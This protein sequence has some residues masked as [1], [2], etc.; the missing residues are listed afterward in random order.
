M[1]I[2]SRYIYGSIRNSWECRLNFRYQEYI[3]V[4]RHYK[5]MRLLLYFLNRSIPFFPKDHIGLTPIEQKLINVEVPFIDK[6]SGLALIKVLDKNI[7]YTMML[8]L[9]FIW[10]LATLDITNSSLDSHIW[11]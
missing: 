3:W 4:R 8:K 10:N 9:K 11:S 5:F 2:D 7:H 1:D 6:I